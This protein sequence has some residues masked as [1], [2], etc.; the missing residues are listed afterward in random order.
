MFDLFMRLLVLAGTFGGSLY[1]LGSTIYRWLRSGYWHSMTV[2]DLF[3]IDNPFFGSNWVGLARLLDW[4]PI[5]LLL[6][7]F[8]VFFLFATDDPV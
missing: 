8:G 5:W 4:L 3:R 6:F 7:V 2:L 1:L